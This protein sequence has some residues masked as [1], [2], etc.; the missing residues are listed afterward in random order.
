[1][2]NSCEDAKQIAQENGLDFNQTLVCQSKDTNPDFNDYVEKISIRVGIYG[3]QFIGDDYLAGGTGIE[4]VKYVA[5][6]TGLS[7]TVGFEQNIYA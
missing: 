5:Y 6:Q 1:M 4:K 3:E 7:T 2:V